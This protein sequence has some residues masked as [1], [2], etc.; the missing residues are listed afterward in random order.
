MLT[1]IDLPLNHTLTR[2]QALERLSAGTLLALGLWPGAVKAEGKSRSGAFR[3]L[4][5]NDTH[6]M[7]PECGAWLERVVRQ[8][9]THEG[10]EFCLHAGDLTDLGKKEDLI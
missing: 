7:S 3:F 4:V 5:I 10:V 8:M 9:K 6:Y 1:P 2:R